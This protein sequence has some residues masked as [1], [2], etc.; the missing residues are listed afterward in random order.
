MLETETLFRR[1]YARVDGR[2]QFDIPEDSEIHQ[3][4]HDILQLMLFAELQK[5]TISLEEEHCIND[6]M[7]ECRLSVD[8]FEKLN[9]RANINLNINLNLNHET[10]I[11]RLA[12]NPNTRQNINIQ[13]YLF[14][15][16]FIKCYEYMQKSEYKKQLDQALLAVMGI[17]EIPSGF[18]PDDINTCLEHYNGRLQSHDALLS[19]LGVVE[20]DDILLRYLADYGQHLD[21]NNHIKIIIK[22]AQEAKNAEAINELFTKISEKNDALGKVIK[23]ILDSKEYQEQYKGGFFTRLQDFVIQALLYICKF[24]KWSCTGLQETVKAQ[25]DITDITFTHYARNRLKNC[26]LGFAQ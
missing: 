15:H 1:L 22:L 14:Y 4:S 23:G 26:L 24:T 20:E 10:D 2:P 9:Q 12:T 11:V 17:T 7:S 3:L 25:K 8:S 5:C 19:V 13:T 21:I 16:S 18:L 6:G